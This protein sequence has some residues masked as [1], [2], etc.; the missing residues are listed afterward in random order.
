MSNLNEEDIA[1]ILAHV[2]W[3]KVNDVD[4]SMSELLTEWSALITELSDKEWRYVSL[5]ESYEAQSHM[6]EE[7]TDFKKLYGKNN[8]E[9]RKHHIKQELYDTFENIK[10]L[11]LSIDYLKRRITFLKQ[12]IHTKTIIM[13]VKQ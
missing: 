13:E 1:K 2:E 3:E 10:L 11:E 4:K 7:T 12:L 9:V 6:I 5:K 8:A